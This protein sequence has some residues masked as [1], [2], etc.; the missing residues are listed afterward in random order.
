MKIDT[1]IHLESDNNIYN[2][3]KV[4][5]NLLDDVFVTITQLTSV[6]LTTLEITLP[7]ISKSMVIP[8]KY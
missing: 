3:S 5:I 4:F 7:R 1:I 8:M 2:F 6:L